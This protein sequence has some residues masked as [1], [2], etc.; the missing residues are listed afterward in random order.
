MKTMRT[1][2]F[3]AAK[4]ALKRLLSRLGFSVTE[5]CHDCGT[6]QPIVWTADDALWSETTEAGTPGAPLVLCE[7]CFDRRAF[8]KGIFIRWIPAVDHRFEPGS[9]KYC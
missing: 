6:E 1:L 9:R 5:F 2:P 3:I 8:H 4:K 7:K